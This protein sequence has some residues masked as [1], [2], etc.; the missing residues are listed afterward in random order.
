YSLV[1]QNDNKKDESSNVKK[2]LLFIKQKGWIT[3]CDVE[4]LLGISS[5]SALR[6]IKNMVESGILVKQGNG[7]DVKYT[8]KHK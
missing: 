3:R 6:F 4:E 5:S 8:L 7:K 2:V 1:E